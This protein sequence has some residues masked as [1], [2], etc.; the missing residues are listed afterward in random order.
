[1]ARHHFALGGEFRDMETHLR[2]RDACCYG[3]LRVE[4][5]TM[6]FQ[7]LQNFFHSLDRLA[8]RCVENFIDCDF[9]HVPR[10]LRRRVQCIFGRMKSLLIPSY[11]ARKTMFI[12]AKRVPENT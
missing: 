6:I 4:L 12:L 3:N 10:C 9:R 11:Q 1:M 8:L 5:L 2:Q 7:I